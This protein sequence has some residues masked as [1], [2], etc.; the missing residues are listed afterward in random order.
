[1]L[2]RQ[3]PEEVLLVA[4]LQQAWALE[5]VLVLERELALALGLE[6]GAVGTVAETEP[7]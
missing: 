3:E 7:V 1:M 5:R 6:L 2:V 4:V